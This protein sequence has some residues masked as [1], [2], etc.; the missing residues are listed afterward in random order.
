M[1]PIPVTGDPSALL[2]AQEQAVCPA[3]GNPAMPTLRFDSDA[4]SDLLIAL[5]TADS[6]LSVLIPSNQN[7]LNPALSP[8]VR[9][10]AFSTPLPV[11][12]TLRDVVLANV[13]Q[14]LLQDLVAISTSGGTTT[15]TPFIGLG[16]GLFFTDPSLVTSNLPFNASRLQSANVD[17]KTDV[18]FPDLVLFED[19]DLAPFSLL[20]TLR[21]R[22]DIDDSGRVDGYDLALL[23]ASFGAERGEDFILL[24]DATFSRSGSGP[25]QVIQRTGAA[26]PGQ[27][28][29]DSA[30]ACN[31]SFDAGIGRYGVPVDI[32]LDGIIDGEDLALLAGRFGSSPR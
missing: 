4:K 29:P 15:V 9:P 23:A 24:P 5:G 14:D 2:R 16:N 18:L 12:G 6:T 13:N 28:L 19:R 25:T 3:A 21:E 8:L 26:V 1:A 32:N 27:E 10:V 17:I 11:P 30:G 20:N 22:A 31:G 7:Y